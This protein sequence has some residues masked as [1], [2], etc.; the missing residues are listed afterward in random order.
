MKVVRPRHDC[1]SDEKPCVLALYLKISMKEADKVLADV[2]AQLAT[3]QELGKAGKT[4]A[5]QMWKGKIEPCHVYLLSHDRR[6]RHG[7]LP[8][9]LSHQSCQN[10]FPCPHRDA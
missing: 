9:P 10:S 3:F 2:D 1:Q 6:L 5:K 8:G 7:V 4:T